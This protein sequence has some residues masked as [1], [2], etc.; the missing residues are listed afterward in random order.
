MERV[1]K[2]SANRH[3]DDDW[4]RSKQMMTSENRQQF[5]LPQDSCTSVEALQIEC[6]SMR[7]TLELYELWKVSE[8]V[9]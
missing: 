3:T 8:F 9:E 6:R 2:Y 7:F 5:H 1:E 4:K